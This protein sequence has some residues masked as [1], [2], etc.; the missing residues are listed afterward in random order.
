MVLLFLY[1]FCLILYL[2]FLI[3]VLLILICK[4]WCLFYEKV[5]YIYIVSILEVVKI[6]E[7]VGE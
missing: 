3:N 1:L 4:K 6:K 5:S 2:L 7:L